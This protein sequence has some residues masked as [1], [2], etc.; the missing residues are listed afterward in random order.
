MNLDRDTFRP[1][2]FASTPFTVHPAPTPTL[3]LPSTQSL[4]TLAST[5]AATL[6]HGRVLDMQ[7]PLRATPTPNRASGTGSVSKKRSREYF[8]LQF[9]EAVIEV[10][11]YPYARTFIFGPL[12]KNH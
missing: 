9:S 3:V 8:P 1:W 6:T 10:S 7:T 2:L 11:S 4:P 12:T 5:Q